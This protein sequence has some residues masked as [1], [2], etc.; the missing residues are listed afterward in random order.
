MIVRQSSA[1]PRA[2]TPRRAAMLR[3]DIGA[4][5][6]CFHRSTPTASGQGKHRDDA[7]PLHPH[8]APPRRRRSAA[9][10]PGAVR[11]SA[12]GRRASTRLDRRESGIGWH[13]G[14]S[15]SGGRWTGHRYGEGPT[16]KD[17]DGR[18]RRVGAP[19]GS[20][21]SDQVA[22]PAQQPRAGRFAF[23]RN[24]FHPGEDGGTSRARQGRRGAKPQ[25]SGA[26]ATTGAAGGA[27]PP[28]PPRSAE[29]RDVEARSSM[30]RAPEDPPGPLPAPR[31]EGGGL[32]G[33]GGCGFEPRRASR[34]ARTTCRIDRGR[35]AR[36]RLSSSPEG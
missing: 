30:G 14:Q 23:P 9:R 22:P 2:E 7:G 26:N 15:E 4:R 28:V 18:R 17:R 20:D 21:G 11:G 12:V 36:A 29:R 19:P 16:R 8:R 10:E 13:S 32:S 35:A 34:L 27:L 33:S 1:L 3:R 5:L 6:F 31:A 24:T 25:A